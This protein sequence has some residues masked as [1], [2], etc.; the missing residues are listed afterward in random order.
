M[1]DNQR[2]SLT[3]MHS[4]HETTAAALTWTLYALSRAPHVQ[5]KLRDALYDL[6]IPSTSIPSADDFQRI[7]SEPYLDACLREALRVHTP[8]TN[9]M[10]IARNDDCVPV[11]QPYRDKAGQLRDH[12]RL[13]KGDIITIPM[14]AINKSK[15][16]WGE[17]ADEFAPDRWLDSSNIKD[18]ER[19]L[20]GLWGGILT[21]GSGHVVNGNRSCIGYRFAINE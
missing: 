9:T 19:A 15:A 11:S 4:G 17:D 18:R 10:R 8:V 2:G 6:H 7:L 21:F 14:Q 3:A 12:I 5:S 1:S 13:K 16:I 20:K